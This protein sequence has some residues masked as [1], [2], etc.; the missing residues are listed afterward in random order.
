MKIFFEK[1]HGTG[2]DFILVDDRENRIELSASRIA[3][4]CHR[5]FGIGADGLILLRNA[6]GFDF[7]M[8]YFNS[9]GLPGSMCGN[10][11][12]CITAF[13]KSLGI[14]TNRAMF[15][16]SDGVHTAEILSTDPIIVKL[17]MADV[18]SVDSNP[19]F[20]FL[21]TGSPHVVRFIQDV[22]HTDVVSIG[23]QIR[24][25]ERYK[26]GGAN[27]NFVEIR[28]TELYVRTYE[29]GVEDETLS[30]GTGVT[31]AALASVKKGLAF[32]VNG[33]RHLHTPGG[34][35]KVHYTELN[36][37]FVDVFLEGPA[38]KVFSGQ[39]EL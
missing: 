27:V 11:G 38:L 36:G 20:F 21:N 2:N 17:K 33:I 10:G 28:G 9:D 29:R 24:N 13:A 6:A 7:E 31:A 5:R 23:R 19:D 16:A 39:L 18:K 26:P 3:E 4:I 30:C 37:G 35:L 8:N 1:Y 25:Q 34:L 12:R 32:P 15:I 22:E 14:I